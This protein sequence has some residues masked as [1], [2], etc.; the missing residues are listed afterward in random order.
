MRIKHTFEPPHLCS[1]CYWEERARQQAQINKLL[2]AELVKY[3]GA[4]RAA[5]K[6]EPR[7]RDDEER[8]QHH[9][10]DV[11]DE[12]TGMGRICLDD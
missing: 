4:R 9:T 7:E 8:D 10:P 2:R 6:P 12:M 3:T 1:N 11:L 5:R